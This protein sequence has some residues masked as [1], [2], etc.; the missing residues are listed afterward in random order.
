MNSFVQITPEGRFA[1][2]GKR[3]YCNSVIYYGHR[4]GAMRNWFTDDVWP[5]NQSMLDEDFD[6]MR[7]IGINHAA[8]F[9]SSEMFFEGGKPA[10]RGYERMDEVVAAAK[11]RGVRLTLFSGPFIDNEA[12]YFR[13]TGREWK[14]GNRWLPAFNEA[15]FEAYVDQMRPLAERY[16]DE[17]AVLGYADRID[18]FFKGFDNVSIP[19]NLKDEW[20]L[21]LKDRYGTMANLKEAVGGALEGNPADFGDVIL[22]QESVYNASLKNPLAYDYIL[23]QKKVTGDAQARWDAEMMKTAPRQVYWT[24]FEG[25]S[26]DW[27]MLDGFTPETKKLNAIWMEYYHQQ[28]MRSFPVNPNEWNHTCEVVTQRLH[29]K[30]PTIYNT[31]YLFTRYIKLSVQQPVVICHGTVMDNPIRGADTERHQLAIIDRVNA[32]CL[33][34]DC[35]GWHYWCFTD[36]WQ[37]SLSHLKEQKDKPYLMYYQGESMG[38]YDYDNH[39]R[40][41]VSLVRMYSNELQRRIRKAAPPKRGE[42]LLLSGAALN[43]SLFRRMAT[44]TA[45]AVNGALARLGVKCDYLW[46]AQNDIEISQETLNQYKLIVMADHIYGRDYIDMP[47]KLLKYVEGGGTL[48]FASDRYDSFKDEHGVPHKNDAI[49][50]LTGAYDPANTNDW[51]GADTPCQNWPF[52]TEIAHEP[53]FDAAELS[54]LHWGICPDFRHYAAVS[55]R[56]QLIGFRTLDGDNFTGV[57]GIPANAEVIAVAKFAKGSRP[58]VYRHKLG[59]GVVYVN[60]WTNNVFR[61]SDHHTDYG[62]WDYD[63]IL[64]PALETARLEDADIIG[65]AAIWL[66]NTWGYYWKDM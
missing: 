16:K 27:A 5:F 22:P 47:D 40:P 62:G 13:I 31:A 34:A 41:V 35:D 32:A 7:T 17:P 61:D 44:P 4:P 46:T 24:P 49:L 55:Q 6:K 21:M 59:D 8:L 18:R 66:R 25:C 19:F 28:S 43:Y 56:Q 38:L 33:A 63:W 57:P 50:K 3:W 14:Y 42:V 1:L 60:A 36:D 65:G 51:P 9:L 54:R 52:K 23:W 37:S 26:L 11:R 53:N 45:S 29:D 15:L 58:F 12:E 2:D 30:S 10:R 39:P 64:A 48:Y 20:A